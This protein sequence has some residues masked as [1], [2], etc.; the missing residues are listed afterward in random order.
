MWI[1]PL[2]C[3]HYSFACGELCIGLCPVRQVFVWSCENDSSILVA[4]ATDPESCVDASILHCL[5]HIEQDWHDFR[6]LALCFDCSVEKVH[7]AP[8]GNESVLD[9]KGNDGT[10]SAPC[11]YLVVT[12][13]VTQTTNHR[14]QLNGLG[15]TY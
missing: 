13:S 7:V 12:L 1:K 3:L 8:E 4:V 10:L 11:R 5:V 9:S 14:F 15:V 2:A 6:H